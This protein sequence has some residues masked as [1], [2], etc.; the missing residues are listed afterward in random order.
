LRESP[1]GFFTN[2]GDS[3]ANQPLDANREAHR[4]RKEWPV[5]STQTRHLKKMRKQNQSDQQRLLRQQSAQYLN[6]SELPFTVPL[7]LPIVDPD[8]PVAGTAFDAA[9]IPR[10]G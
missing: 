6:E 9:K 1:S 3:L 4:A 2:G 10:K 5:K 7:C 8:R